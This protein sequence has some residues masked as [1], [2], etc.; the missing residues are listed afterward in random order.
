MARLP[1]NAEEEATPTLQD[2]GPV[3]A[4]RDGEWEVGGEIQS[5]RPDGPGTPGANCGWQT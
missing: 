3:R 2:R 1:E 4:I 5:A